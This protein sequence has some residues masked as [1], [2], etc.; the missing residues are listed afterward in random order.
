MN[1]RIFWREGKCVMD[2]P[3]NKDRIV[4]FAF[5]ISKLAGTRMLRVGKFLNKFYV[6]CVIVAPVR[7]NCIA[8]CYFDE[9]MQWKYM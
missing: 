2:A 1:E 3:R 8:S 6:S 5:A 9:R 4:D 7:S